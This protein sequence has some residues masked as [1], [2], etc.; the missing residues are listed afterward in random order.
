MS[1]FYDRELYISTQRDLY[2]LMHF[3]SM[4]CVFENTVT[5]GQAYTLMSRSCRM[6]C[7]CEVSDVKGSVICSCVVM[8]NYE[9]LL[10]EE[11]S[12]RVGSAGSTPSGREMDR[13]RERAIRAQPSMLSAHAWRRTLCECLQHTRVNARTAA[14]WN[15][16]SDCAC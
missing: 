8:E 3:C 6:S 14:C 2:E 7:R 9:R 13:W 16:E 10:E 5:Q 1:L 4:S 12:L 11:S 15:I